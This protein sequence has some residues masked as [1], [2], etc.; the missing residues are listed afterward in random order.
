MV[1]LNSEKKEI[2]KRTDPDNDANMKKKVKNDKSSKK[3]KDQGKT[4]TKC[5]AEKHPLSDQSP[6]LKKLTEQGKIP[7][8]RG[9]EKH[10]L[11]GQSPSSRNSK[12]GST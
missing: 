11:S 6:N 12:D 4:L 9:A 10:P 3:S 5:G 8:K 2:L 1:N 7:A